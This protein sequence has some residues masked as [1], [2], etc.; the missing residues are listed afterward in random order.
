MQ[1]NIWY[2]IAILFFSSSL[3]ADIYSAR[4]NGFDQKSAI[5][6]AKYNL[7]IK[8]QTEY[9][10]SIDI[11]RSLSVESISPDS[12]N[13]NAENLMVDDI[14]YTK[15]GVDLEA[16]FDVEVINEHLA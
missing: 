1:K 12:D 16:S 5:E 13:Y 4:G 14:R 15:S 7:L 9:L 2:I 3:N 10:K 6:D 11:C 8:A